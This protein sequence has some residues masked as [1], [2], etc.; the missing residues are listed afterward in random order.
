MNRRF[1]FRLSTILIVFAV[2]S[3]GLAYYVAD[4]QR[5][6]KC[7]VSRGGLQ[8]V[9]ADGREVEIVTA[10]NAL[11]RTIVVVVLHY[12][13]K[14]PKRLI[15]E[16]GRT[17]SSN[18]PIEGLQ[19]SYRLTSCWPPDPNASGLWIDGIR[20]SVGNELTCVYISD[21]TEATIIEIPANDVETF[22]DNI[23]E[24]DP[25]R[26]IDKWIAKP[27]PDAG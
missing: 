14:N 16:P 19:S 15:L 7:L 12:S 18:D 4:Q 8:Q 9:Y 21:R 26:F 22:L 3:V 25:L 2:L 1:S 17:Y 20:H 10:G 23:G 13:T 6:A 11:D 24:I 27:A 5:K